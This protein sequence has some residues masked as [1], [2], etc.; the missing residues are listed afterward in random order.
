M[1]AVCLTDV[2]DEPQISEKLSDF[3]DDSL[4]LNLRN[5]LIRILP[6]HWVERI[7]NIIT[8]QAKKYRGSDIAKMCK[9]N[10]NQFNSL[11]EMAVFVC[12]QAFHSN[13]KKEEVTRAAKALTT[14]FSSK[15]IIKILQYLLLSN[16]PN[17]FSAVFLPLITAAKGVKMHILLK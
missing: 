5:K 16:I 3:L 8:F 4:Y 9:L 2:S 14:I 7:V 10:G 6:Q 12:D 17:H 1:T 13:V 11:A 15:L